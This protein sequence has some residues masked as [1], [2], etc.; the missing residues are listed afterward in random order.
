MFCLEKNT[1]MFCDLY[2]IPNH[3]IDIFIE[4]GENKVGHVRPNPLYRT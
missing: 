2:S 1:H 4:N 3:N